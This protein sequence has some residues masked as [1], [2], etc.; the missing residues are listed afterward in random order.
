MSILKTRLGFVVVV[1][2]GLGVLWLGG[3]SW[4]T[5][6]WAAGFDPESIGNPGPD[7]IRLQVWTNKDPGEAF[8]EGE[9]LVIYFQADRQAYLTILAVSAKGNVRVVFPNRE[10]PDNMIEKDKFYTVF[11]DDSQIWLHLVKD[12]G[13]TRLAFYVS[14]SPFDFSPLKP[15]TDMHCI[16]IP[17]D[18]KAHMKVLTDKL[19]A[20]AKSQGFNRLILSLQGEKDERFEINLMGGSG[21]G[22]KPLPKRLPVGN[23]SQPPETLTGTQGVK[24]DLTRDR[25]APGK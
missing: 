14:A 23:E 12:E 21:I 11:G 2:V 19:D 20:V 16:T 8:R 1:V 6:A 4:G 22:T 10:L 5:D 3:V 25:K 13:Q 7:A 15:D 24:D 9:R 17:A 18:G